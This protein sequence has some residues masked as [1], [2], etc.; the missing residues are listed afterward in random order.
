MLCMKVTIAI[1]HII[2]YVLILF[3]PLEN[4]H[5]V[6]SGFRSNVISKIYLHYVFNKSM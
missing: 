4:R 5:Y 6:D 2:M 1:N 3:R